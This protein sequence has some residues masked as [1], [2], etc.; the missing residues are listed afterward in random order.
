[1]GAEQGSHT[2]ADSLGPLPGAPIFIAPN[3]PHEI[4][5][6]QHDGLPDGWVLVEAE[7]D[8]G[9]IEAVIMSEEDLT[10]IVGSQRG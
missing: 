10:A 7:T 6:V 2:V 1:M 8:D 3:D 4:M 5:G 9:G